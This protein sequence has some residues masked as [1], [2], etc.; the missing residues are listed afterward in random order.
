MYT[1]WLALS[2]KTLCYEYIQLLI[3]KVN[4]LIASICLMAMFGHLA[5]G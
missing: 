1:K 2:L 3:P 4:R 5:L